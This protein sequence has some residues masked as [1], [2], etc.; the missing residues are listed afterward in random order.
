MYHTESFLKEILELGKK[1][2]NTVTFEFHPITIKI[3]HR[4]NTVVTEE[5][6]VYLE[7]HYIVA[8]TVF[9]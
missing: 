7:L 6:T 4:L 3:T 5:C 1:K 9:E 2:K 8:L